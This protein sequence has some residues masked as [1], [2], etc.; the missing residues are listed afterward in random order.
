MIDNTVIVM[1][2]NTVIVIILISY[3]V[4]IHLF[5]ISSLIL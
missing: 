4:E 3:I 1:I 2:D 5:A